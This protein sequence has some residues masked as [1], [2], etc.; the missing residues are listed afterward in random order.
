MVCVSISFNALTD[1]S[2]LLTVEESKGNAKKLEKSGGSR[3]GS[4]SSGSSTTK[5][6]R[7]PSG[8]EMLAQLSGIGSRDASLFLFRALGK[9]LYCKRMCACS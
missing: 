6:R 5:L 8:C 7:H 3:Q 2:D 4:K 1:C 9:I